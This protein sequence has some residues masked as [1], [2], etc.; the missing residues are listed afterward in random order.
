MVDRYSFFGRK[1]EK[2]E[3]SLKTQGFAKC[4]RRRRRHTRM[5][6]SL[7][8]RAARRATL[9]RPSDLQTDLRAQPTDF[10]TPPTD[11]QTDLQTDFRAR[12]A[13]FRAQPSDLRA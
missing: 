2:M 6:A 3:T 1:F 10:R 9:S 12:P 5:P 8:Q 4:M 7:Q 13:D 11:L